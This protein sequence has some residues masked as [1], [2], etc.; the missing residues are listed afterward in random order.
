MRTVIIACFA[1]ASLLF[2]GCAATRL[3]KEGAETIAVAYVGNIGATVLHELGHFESSQMHF[4]KP[5]A[6]IEPYFFEVWEERKGSYNGWRWKTEKP[7]NVGTM[8]WVHGN[9]AGV[10]ASQRFYFSMHEELQAGTMQGR[11]AHALAFFLGIDLIEYTWEDAS[12]FDPSLRRKYALRKGPENSVTYYTKSA[13]DP[14]GDM[15][16]YALAMGLDK[17]DL[18]RIAVVDF[19]GKAPELLWHF[20]GMCGIERSPPTFLRFG[21]CA[22]RPGIV[23]TQW[24]MYPGLTLTLRF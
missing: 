15:V 12:D 24:E 16:E 11:G 13:N 1:F 19:L 3:A 4:A 18:Q 5:D 14:G 23:M 7:A 6:E 10:H 21:N 9:L 2:G 22:I 17:E 20:Q 8:R